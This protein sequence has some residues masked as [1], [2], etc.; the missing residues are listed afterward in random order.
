MTA[1]NSLKRLVRARMRKTGESYSSARRYFHTEDYEMTNA[2]N[3]LQPGLW[4]DWVEGHPWLVS[5]LTKA[6]AE[7]RNRGDTRCDHF[8]I[9]LA[10]LNL[11]PPVSRWLE[12]LGLDVRELREDTVEI[13][14]MNAEVT[15][16]ADRDEAWLARGARA[17]AARHSD[18]PVAD[19]PLESVDEIYTGELL[20]LARGE[21]ELH[22]DSVD[23]RHSLVALAVLLFAGSP[24]TVGALRHLTGL[25]STEDTSYD[26]RIDDDREW[27][28]RLAA[29]HGADPAMF[30]YDIHGPR[31]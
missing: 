26:V 18:N 4:P 23:E 20:E 3:Q 14:G 24:P 10:F 8:H 30:P 27:M 25:S 22:G 9:E 31:T 15:L 1:R 12:T 11:G 6:E 28:R 13:L 29:S 5:F 2:I 7:A 19:C 21:A 17:R 16:G